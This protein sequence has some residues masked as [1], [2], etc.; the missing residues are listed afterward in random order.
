MEQDSG[1]KSL[2]G[3]PQKT[4]IAQRTGITKES[5]WYQTKNWL[6]QNWSREAS[7][8]GNGKTPTTFRWPGSRGAY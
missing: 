4:G 5:N 2:R 6:R 1:T 3:L 7:R 8:A